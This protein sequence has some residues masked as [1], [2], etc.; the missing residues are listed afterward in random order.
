MCA[1]LISDVGMFKACLRTLAVLS[2]KEFTALVQRMYCPISACM[3]G[4][5]RIPVCGLLMIC[6]GCL[7]PS[8]LS[9]DCTAPAV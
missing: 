8:A 4:Y 2:R 6:I 5:H 9:P 7:K 3:L 1:E